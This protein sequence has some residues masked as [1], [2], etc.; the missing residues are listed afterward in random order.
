MQNDLYSNVPPTKLRNKKEEFI[1][2]HKEPFWVWLCDRY[3]FGMLENEFYAMRVKNGHKYEER[4]KNYSSIIYAPHAN[5]W[6]GQVG[7]NL[8]RRVFDTDIIMMIEELGRFPILSK[9][10]A[11]SINKKSAQESMKALQYSVEQLKDP[12][13]GLWIFPQGIVRPPNFRPIEFQSGMTYIA[14]NCVKKYGGVNLIPVAVNY[15]FLREYSPEILVEVGDPIVLK[16]ADTDR[17]E[18]TKFL[19]DNFTTLCDRQFADISA[20]NLSEYEVIFETKVSW[21]KQIERKLKEIK[22]KRTRDD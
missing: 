21:W 4:D 8:C 16:E 18:V 7:Y 15:S 12:K 19:E 20:G 3:L 2:V 6:D 13:R 9:A 17:H 5:W 1:E 11:F 22:L 10:G 14:Q